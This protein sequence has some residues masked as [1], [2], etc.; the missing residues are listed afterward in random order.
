MAL[1]EMELDL[2]RLENARNR[3]KENHSPQALARSLEDLLSVLIERLS[4][5][6]AI[7]RGG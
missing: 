7:E 4:E 1:A 2:E 5:E 3:I 6:V